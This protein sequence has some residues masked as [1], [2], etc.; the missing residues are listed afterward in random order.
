[1]LVNWL[2]KNRMNPTKFLAWLEEN[3]ITISYEYARSMF[4]GKLTPGP[5][6]K[7]VFKAITGIELQ[8]GLIEVERP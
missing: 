4:D 8:D 6:F 5:K 7:S 3:G 2:S 1:M